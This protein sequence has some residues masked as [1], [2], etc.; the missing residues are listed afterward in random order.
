MVCDFRVASSPAVTFT[1][2]E[3]KLGVSPALISKLVLL[4]CLM[5]NN[6]A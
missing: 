1:L 3:V 4:K 2:S 5:M 6:L